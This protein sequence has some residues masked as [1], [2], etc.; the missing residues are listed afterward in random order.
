MKRVADDGSGHIACAAVQELS[1]LSP[2]EAA[3]LADELARWP[4]ERT[5]DLLRKVRGLSDEDPGVEFESVFGACL[6]SVHAEVRTFSVQSLSESV[7]R[8]L[9]ARFANMVEHDPDA[10]VRVAAASAMST[11]C[12]LAAN[13]KLHPKHTQAV[14]SALG[15]VFADEAQGEELRR[16]ALESMSSFGG[17]DVAAFISQAYASGT[18][19]MRQSAIFAMG[20][21]PDTRWLKTVI[22]ELDA[23][24]SEVRYEA[25]IAL[26]ELGNE[27]HAAY[28][29]SALD[30]TDLNVQVAAVGALEMLGGPQ[31][32]L[33]L[34]KAVRSPEP[35][36]AAA[37]VESLAAIRAEDGLV[38][39]ISADIAESGGLFGGPASVG[40]GADDGDDEYD[41]ADREGWGKAS[42]GDEARRGDAS[43]DEE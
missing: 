15:N 20:R 4:L 43:T 16:R 25:V 19:P 9:A 22:K 38:D 41:A 33:L 11:V 39:T 10:G 18:G 36:V 14:K 30:D 32:R 37:A 42:G 40:S 17:D 8:T 13:G 6:G 24:E 7:D 1:A 28:L 34:L 35:T 5:M 27:E 12:L 21:S 2:A 26:G 31:A 29:R 23:V 3:A